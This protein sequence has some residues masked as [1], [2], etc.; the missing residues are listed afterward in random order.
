VNRIAKDYPETRWRLSIDD[1][2][3]DTLLLMVIVFVSKT[4]WL[5]FKKSP[6]FT[7]QLVEVLFCSREPQP[8][9]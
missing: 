9:I 3:E 6:A 5:R 4:M 1:E 7:L 8:C 2:F